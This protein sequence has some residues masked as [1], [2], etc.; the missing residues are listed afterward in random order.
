MND[1]QQRVLKRLVESLKIGPWNEVKLQG[2]QA[3]LEANLSV[4]EKSQIKRRVE[5]AVSHLDECIHLMDEA[6]GID[7]GRR[8]CESLVHDIEAI[9]SV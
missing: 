1:H 9:I 6:E 3:D 7:A 5:A 2:V 4:L 8:L